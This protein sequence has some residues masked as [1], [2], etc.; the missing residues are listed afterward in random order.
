MVPT[1]KLFV[2]VFSCYSLVIRSR[3]RLK[4]RAAMF[5]ASRGTP[6]STH[7]E[8]TFR[9]SVSRHRPTAGSGSSEFDRYPALLPYS[10]K[11]STMTMA[12][13]TS[14]VLSGGNNGGDLEKLYDFAGAN[15][16]SSATAQQHY[17]RGGGGPH[18]YLCTPSSSGYT[19]TDYAPTIGGGD[20]CR[21]YEGQAAVN[22]SQRSG[23]TPSGSVPGGAMGISTTCPLCVV[24]DCECQQQE[25]QQQQ[26]PGE[27]WMTALSA[28][29]LQPRIQESTFAD[30]MLFYD[31]RAPAFVAADPQTSSGG[32]P[33]RLSGGNG[34][35][36]MTMFKVQQQQQQQHE[37]TYY[38][39]GLRSPDTITTTTSSN[40]TSG[41]ETVTNSNG[42][43]NGTIQVSSFSQS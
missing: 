35:Q 6:D 21:T 11:S 32:F 25:Q 2:L 33:R 9:R 24:H 7:G 3:R 22:Y 28:Q 37:M 14:T 38:P 10:D 19:S 16:G 13:T 4:K 23:S 5:M 1:I 31:H 17:L 12:T 8:P 40:D 42:V 30:G 27:S 18:R 36:L 29:Q 43:G 15:S 39:V 26:Q 41:G 34:E 20:A